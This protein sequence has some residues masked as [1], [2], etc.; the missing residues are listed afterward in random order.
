MFMHTFGQLVT[1][2]ILRDFRIKKFGDS[3]YVTK[4]VYVPVV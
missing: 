1:F 2:D 4:R 3:W